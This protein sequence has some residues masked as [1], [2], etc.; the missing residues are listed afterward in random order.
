MGYTDKTAK[1]MFK[2]SGYIM[3]CFPDLSKKD[4][5]AIFDYLD[6]QPYDPKNYIHRSGW[7][8]R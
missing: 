7:K 4:I 8:R 6:S 3:Q 2:K 5:N 1:A